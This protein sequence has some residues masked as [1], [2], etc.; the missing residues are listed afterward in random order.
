MLSRK[1]VANWASKDMHSRKRREFT[2]YMILM[3]PSI[4]S[5]SDQAASSGDVCIDPTAWIDENLGESA[6][7]VQELYFAARGAQVGAESPN[8]YEFFSR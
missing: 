5:P 1:L 7:P 4:S 8:A 2:C 3:I 6:F